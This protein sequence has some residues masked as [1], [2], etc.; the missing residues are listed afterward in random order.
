MEETMSRISNTIT[1]EQVQEAIRKFE[2]A[3]GLITK[4][5]DESTPGRSLVG[6][7][8]ASFDLVPVDFSI[9]QS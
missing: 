4:L 5:P 6:A 1:E 7:N 2:D 9:L 8:W 3:G